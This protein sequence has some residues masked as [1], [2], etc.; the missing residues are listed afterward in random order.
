VD[1]DEPMPEQ[2]VLAVLYTAGRRPSIDA[3]RLAGEATGAFALTFD[4]GECAGWAELLV[5]GLTFEAAGLAPGPGEALPAIAHRFGLAPDVI[6]DALEAVVI[7]PGNHLAGAA[8][9]LPVV[10]GCV[11]LGAALATHTGA[12]AVVWIPARS[13]MAPD[14]FAAPVGDWLGGGAFPALGLT[15]LVP[16]ESGMISEGLA[17]FTGQELEVAGSDLAQVGRI[18]VRMVHALT[19]QGP[20]TAPN[21]LAGPEGEPLLAEPSGDG[22]RVRVR[23]QP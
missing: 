7:R 9:M 2:A 3:V 18:A 15:A 13:A 16:D 10:R 17:F 5:T 23:A 20:L 12:A 22:S 11:A 19:S 21:R 1:E 14:Y 8:A 6:G 4:P